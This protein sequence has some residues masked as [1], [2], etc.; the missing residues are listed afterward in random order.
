VSARGSRQT[1]ELVGAVTV[2]SPTGS[3]P[4]FRLTW[5]DPDGRRGGTSAG[6]DRAG[7]L[8]KAAAK[9]AELSRSTGPR[10][11]TPLGEVGDAYTATGVGR[12]QHYRR[13][14]RRDWTETHRIQT[15]RKI[16]RALDGFEDVLCW[17]VDRPLLDK[18]RAQGG[19]EQMVQDLTS[20]LRGLLRWGHPEGYFSAGQA[21][22]LP[23][24]S[25]LVKPVRPSTPAPSRRAQVREAGASPD[26][27]RP[28]DAPSNDLV[29]ALGQQLNEVFP[30]WG[31]LAAEL[32]AYC[33]PRWGEQFQ[34]TAHDVVT[35]G[36]HPCLVID[37]QVDPMGHADDVGERRKRPKGEKTRIVGIPEVT[38][39]GFP[40][41]RA[42]VRRAE[43][44]RREQAAEGAYNPDGLLFPT[45]TGRLFHHS[46]FHTDYAVPA[47]IAA[48]WPHQFWSSTRY[49]RDG[50]TG[51]WVPVEQERLQME[52]TWH[53]LRHRFARFC[54]DDLGMKA[55][56]LMAMGG[57]DDINVVMNRYYNSGQEHRDAGVRLMHTG[58]RSTAA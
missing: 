7:A 8:A 4:Y 50:E 9:D 46:S 53:S 23:D 27:I 22:L 3:D 39:T 2:L 51:P 52:L 32:A 41:L 54:I 18:A 10:A 30:R 45:V 11:A 43:T 14:G 40:L 21:Q 1:G 48:G 12:N 34:L 33:G 19:T 17:E 47:A 58:G 42:L 26:F 49:L 56:E 15:R 13:T 24:R 36:A 5:R 20:A 16:A 31:R 37:W 29:R 6:R 38:P 55:P 25:P 28:E 35:T 57:W 44:A